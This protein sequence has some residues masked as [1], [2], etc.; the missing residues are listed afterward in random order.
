MKGLIIYSLKTLRT[1]N[2]LKEHL[3]SFKKYSSFTLN[4]L[5]VKEKIPF[6]ISKKEYDFIILHYSFLADE[7]FLDDAKHWLKKIKEIKNFKA[8]KVAIPQDECLHSNRLSSFFKDANI[9]IICTLFTRDVDIKKVYLKSKTYT[10]KIIKVLTGYIDNESLT[11]LKVVPS[12]SKRANDF[13]YRVRSLGENHGKHAY[14]KTILPLKLKKYLDDKGF[15]TDFG[16]A[17]DDISSLTKNT[18]LGDRW[19]K[20]LLSTKFIIGS[21]SG[22]SL[23]DENGE[24][25]K[26]VIDFKRKNPNA[27][28][29]QV[30]KKCFKN[31]DYNVNYF[32][33]GPKNLEAILTKTLQV[34]LEGDYNK[35]I[36][37]SKH[38]IELKKD[39]SN[40]NEVINKLK[41]LEFCQKFVD[42]AKEDIINNPLFFYDDFVKKILFEVEKIFKKNKITYSNKF[43]FKIIL[44]PFHNYFI[45]IYGE[46]KLLIK[47]FLFKIGFIK[48]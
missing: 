5:N 32:M 18:K 44:L 41:D 16:Y 22:A 17:D 38:F 10:P 29:D 35:M 37:P 40:I 31:I 9:D 47:I 12:L 34:L 2:T 48:V 27:L 43:A 28:F 1:R 24:V 19:F 11:K 42:E 15:I 26:K 39:F 33:M 23:L 4:Y 21:E 13:S 6:W 7:R 46:L 3:F 45:R 20:F 25:Q 8:I 14:Y 30:E 36:K